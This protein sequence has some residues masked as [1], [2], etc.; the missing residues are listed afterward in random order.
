MIL[1]FYNFKI[2]N[3]PPAASFALPF[4][5]NGN[6]S[7]AAIGKYYMYMYACIRPPTQTFLDNLRI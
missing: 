4:T 5:F 2:K 7:L 1:F 3:D 6:M